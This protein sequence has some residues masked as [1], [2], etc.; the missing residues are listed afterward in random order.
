VIA[1]PLPYPVPEEFPS[2][3][4]G[5]RTGRAAVRRRRVLRARSRYAILVRIVATVTLLTVLIG[6]YLALMANVT[7]MNFELSKNAGTEAKL[8]GDSARLEDEISRLASRERLAGIATKLGMHEPDTFA[9]VT[10]PAAH[11]AGER[12]GVAFLPWLK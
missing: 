7:R 5:T 10:L 12:S 9:Q 3:R 1:R 6:V 2:P 4:V 8:A 11:A